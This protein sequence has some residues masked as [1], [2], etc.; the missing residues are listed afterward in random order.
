MTNA[1]I[2]IASTVPLLA[3]LALSACDRPGQGAF[4]TINSSD[5]QTV[6]AV[7]GRSGEVKLALP[8]FSGAFKLPKMS[9][10]ADNFELNGVHLYPGSKIRNVD[11]GNDRGKEFV[12]TFDSPAAPDVVRDWFRQKMEEADFT[13]TDQNG[14]LVGTTAEEKPI[15]IDMR[16]AGRDGSTGTITLGG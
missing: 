12:M 15:R 10:E 8:G 3:A 4:V 6:A 7:D 2:R 1:R 5:G 16:P 11:V 13:L 9:L 14:V